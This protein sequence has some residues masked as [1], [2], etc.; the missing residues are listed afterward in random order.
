MIK[1]NDN[2][3]NDSFYSFPKNVVLRCCLKKHDKIDNEDNG[4]LIPT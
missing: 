2:I 1:K 4:S 3:D